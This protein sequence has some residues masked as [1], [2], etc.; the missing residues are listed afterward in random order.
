MLKYY[1]VDLE[2]SGRGTRHGMCMK[3][4]SKCFAL[5]RECDEDG[6]KKSRSGCA[7]I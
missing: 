7:S 6:G 1:W 4:I 5:Y 3:E 2:S